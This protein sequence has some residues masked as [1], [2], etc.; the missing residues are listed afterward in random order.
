MTLSMF[1]H[2][3]NGLRHLAFDIGEGFQLKTADF[4]SWLVIGFSV[5]A[6]LFTWGLAF[7]TGA[8]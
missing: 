8:L 3:G 6:T 5:A 1:F 7:L 4:T 2:L